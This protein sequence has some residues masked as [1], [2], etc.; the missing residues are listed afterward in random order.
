MPLSGATVLIVDDEVGLTGIFK[1]WFERAGCRVLT[2]ANGALALELA[3]TNCFDLLVS[4]IRMPV[5]DGIELTKRIK[6]IHRYLPKIIFISGFSDLGDRESYDLGVEAK[7]AKPIRRQDLINAAKQ[8][9]MDRLELWRG[10]P[11]ADVRT[12]LEATFESWPIAL[13][14][15][16]IAFGRGG[17]CARSRFA[18]RTGE[19]VG[20][21]LRFEADGHALAGQGI[22]RWTAPQEEQVGIEITSVDEPSLAW[23]CNSLAQNKATSFIPGTAS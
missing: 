8:S 11:H 23:V 14:K 18:A 16:E 4:D 12:T 19:T 2:A 9:M 15:G 5:L 10:P 22:V 17:F 7:L 13:R 3:E 20:L 1:I 21:N 6:A